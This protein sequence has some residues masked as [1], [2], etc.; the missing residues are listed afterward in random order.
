MKIQH[1]LLLVLWREWSF[2][3]LLAV[4]CGAAMPAMAQPAAVPPL[5]AASA[6]NPVLHHAPDARTVQRW[7]QGWRYPQAGWTV[8]HIE[9]E[10]HAR[11]LQHGRLLA[12]EIAGYIRALSQ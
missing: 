12:A 3:L 1:P 5:A 7:G 10:P 4:W 9:G 8:V 11:G 2:V 6:V